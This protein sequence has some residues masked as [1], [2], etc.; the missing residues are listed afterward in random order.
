M[1]GNIFE[2]K[3]YLILETADGKAQVALRMQWGN[4]GFWELGPVLDSVGATQN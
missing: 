2:Y 3:G 4:D 1:N